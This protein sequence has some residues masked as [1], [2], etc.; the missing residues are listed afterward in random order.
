MKPPEM[1]WE[2]YQQEQ[3]SFRQKEH[4]ACNDILLAHSSAR[5][6]HVS[7]DEDPFFIFRF[8]EYTTPSEYYLRLRR[9]PGIVW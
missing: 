9:M 7:T 1:T 4:D 3:R 8:E 6:Y 5:K 2:E